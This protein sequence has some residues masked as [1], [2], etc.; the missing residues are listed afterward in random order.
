MNIEQMY[1]NYKPIKGLGKR[2][3]PEGKFEHAVPVR[4]AIL[5]PP[6]DSDGCVVEVFEARCPTSFYSLHIITKNGTF[7]LDTGSGMADLIGEIAIQF[8]EGMLGVNNLAP[9]SIR[10]LK[11]L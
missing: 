3:K 9:Q 4:V 2:Y 10:Y 7:I 8:S 1:T 6:L 11:E 5:N